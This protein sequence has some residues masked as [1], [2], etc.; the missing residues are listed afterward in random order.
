M[1]ENILLD[2]LSE[3]VEVD[4]REFFIDTDFRTCIIFEKILESDIPNRQKVDE[5][6]SL[7]FPNERP[8]NLNDAIDAIL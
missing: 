2:S 3:T 6:V 4:G 5:F 1:A 8:D 7:F